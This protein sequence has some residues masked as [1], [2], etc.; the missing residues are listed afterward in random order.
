MKRS[1]GSGPR[2]ITWVLAGVFLTALA[3]GPGPGSMLVDGSP[4]APNFLCGVPVLYLWL[5]FW[6]LVM[7][8]CVVV[9]AHCIWR[10]EE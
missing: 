2:R 6:L 5:V 1:L 9:A 10:D 8:G 7:A 3:M 4:A